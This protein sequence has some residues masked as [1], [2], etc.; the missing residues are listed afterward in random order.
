MSLGYSVNGTPIDQRYVSWQSLNLN[1]WKG[2]YTFGNNGV[3]MLGLG[4]LYGKISSP[5]QVGSLTNWKSISAGLEN[6]NA[7]SSDGN[8]W[9]WGGGTYGQSGTTTKTVPTQ[10][11]TTSDWES[12]VCSSTF[13]ILLKTDGSLWSMGRNHRGQLGL[14]NTTNRSSP[15]QVGNLSEWKTVSAGDDFTLAVKK[16]GTL[17]TWGYNGQG[18]LGLSNITSRSSPTQVGNLAN[19]SL[20]AAGRYHSIA[21][22]T[23]G[24]LWTWG[25][26]T[27]G[28]LGIGTINTKYSSPVQV[29][30]LTTWSTPYA[31]NYGNYSFCKQTNNTMWS[32]GD[33]SYGVTGQGVNTGRSSPSFMA[34]GY[35]PEWLTVAPSLSHCLGIKTDGTLWSWGENGYGQLGHNTINNEGAPRQVGALTNWDKI[36]TYFGFSIAAPNQT[37]SIP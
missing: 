24:T 4:Y 10:I 26:N 36:A 14:G 16:D 7:I 15:T 1:S 5:T 2:V 8:L 19:W 27:A 30:S 37:T 11:S 28:Q 35:G 9:A 25:D 13:T 31:A 22:K 34:I 21:V 6:V 33:G 18:Q 20:V 23:D 17:W 32:W 29:G 3:G 12:V